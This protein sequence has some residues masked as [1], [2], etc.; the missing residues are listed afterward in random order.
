MKLIRIYSLTAAA[1]QEAS[2]EA[3]LDALGKMVRAVEG[4]D[5]FLVGRDQGA[6]SA[7]TVLE[8]WR[9]TE[10]HQASASVVPK[11]SFRAIMSTLSE[12]PKMKDVL[13][14]T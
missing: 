12:S 7:Y 9:S 11:D 10:H 13:Q 3:A 8:F 5:D 14:A 4:C 1:G 2:L 6:A